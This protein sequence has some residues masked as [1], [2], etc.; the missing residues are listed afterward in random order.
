MPVLPRLA[1]RHK[2][3]VAAVHDPALT[4]RSVALSGHPPTR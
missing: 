4:D 2:V 1:A 3:V